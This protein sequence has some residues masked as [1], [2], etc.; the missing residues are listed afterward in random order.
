MRKDNLDW[1]GTNYCGKP[2][3]RACEWHN[4]D[5]KKMVGGGKK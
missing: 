4:E 1:C 5:F 2:F 3:V